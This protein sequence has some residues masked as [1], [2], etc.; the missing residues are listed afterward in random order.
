MLGHTLGDA[1][2]RMLDALLDPLDS[3]ADA[4]PETVGL[5]LFGGLDGWLVKVAHRE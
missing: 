1:F 3:F 5:G 4:L 2:D